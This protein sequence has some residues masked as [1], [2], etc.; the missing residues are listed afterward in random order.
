MLVHAHRTVSMDGGGALPRRQLDHGEELEATMLNHIGYLLLGLGNGAVFAAL[1]IALVVTYRS[2][3]VINFATGSIALY[4]AYIY[5]FLREGKFMV[6]IPGL[7]NT[8]D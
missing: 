6:L 5:G 3:G 1:A 2:S 4:T 7:P 8:V